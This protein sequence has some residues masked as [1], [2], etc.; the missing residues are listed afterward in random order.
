MLAMLRLPLLY[1]GRVFDRE[2]WSLKASGAILTGLWSY[3]AQTEAS[4]AAITGLFVLVGLDMVTGMAASLK[5]GKKIS[6]RRSRDT[7]FKAI[8]YLSVIG[9]ASAVERIVPGT[10][11]LV[12]GAIVPL[13]VTE[14][15]SLLENVRY[16]GVRD[17]GVLKRILEAALAHPDDEQMLGPQA[18][19][20][21]KQ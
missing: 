14:L 2:A 9:A 6:S 11:S 15:V 3:V 18:R 1:L 4:A 5:R 20:K 10:V 13:A 12:P 16:L 21:P 7:V 8:A 17:G 19:A